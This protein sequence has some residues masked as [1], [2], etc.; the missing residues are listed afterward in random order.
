MIMCTVIAN[1]HRSHAKGLYRLQY[2]LLQ[3]TL[4]LPYKRCCRSSCLLH[5]DISV[6]LHVISLAA[7]DIPVRGGMYLTSLQCGDAYVNSLTYL[8]WQVGCKVSGHTPKPLS[9]PHVQNV[10]A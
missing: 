5:Q 9:N 3:G 10:T 7:L 8:Y 6:T 4:L 2:W 1:N